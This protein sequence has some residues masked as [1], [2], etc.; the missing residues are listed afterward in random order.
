MKKTYILP[1]ALTI[2]LGTKQTMLVD[3]VP[4]VPGP[5]NPEEF[6]TKEE[7][8]ISKNIWDEEW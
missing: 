8:N 2:V 4:V 3:S 6:E 5:V 1:E 7:N